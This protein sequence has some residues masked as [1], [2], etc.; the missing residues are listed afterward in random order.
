MRNK[1]HST[2]HLVPLAHVTGARNVRKPLVSLLLIAALIAVSIF[3]SSLASSLVQ[4]T[5][6]PKANPHFNLDVAYSFVGQGPNANCTSS[7]GHIMCPE[8]LYPSAV[9][10]NIS[11]TT[12]TDNIS[13]DALI[14]VYSVKIAADKGPIENFIYFDGTNFSPSFTDAQKNTLTARIYE[15]FDLNAIDGVSGNFCFNWTLE[16]SLLSQKVGSYGVYNNYHNGL[17]L[18]S[19]GQPNQIF[20]AVH[21][22]GYVTMTNGIVSVATDA[23]STSITQVQLQNY[24]NSFMINKIVPANQLSQTNPFRP[25]H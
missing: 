17:G 19:S 15:L 13:Y 12:N 14:E 20:V 23:G 21:R 9:Y 1:L 10:F 18:W 3:V 8:S 4:A 11:R 2:K 22:L 5:Q 7:N 25:V 24:G 16:E 6:L